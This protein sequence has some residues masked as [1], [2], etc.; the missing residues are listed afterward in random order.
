[1]HDLGLL[2]VVAL[3]ISIISGMS[4]LAE[5]QKV[6]YEIVRDKRSGKDSA[7]NLQAL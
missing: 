2:P 5:G 7:D 4:T 1:V 3:T 6:G